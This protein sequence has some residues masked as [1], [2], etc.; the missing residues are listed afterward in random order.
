MHRVGAYTRHRR[1]YSMKGNVPPTLD[2]S[3]SQAGLGT[4]A[5]ESD[6]LWMCTYLQ[7]LS[8]CAFTARDLV[9]TPLFVVDV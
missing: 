7:G 1:H 3:K 6:A 2:H 4:V 5:T 8:T 9:A